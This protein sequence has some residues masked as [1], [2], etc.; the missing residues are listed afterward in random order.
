MKRFFPGF[1]VSIL[2]VMIMVCGAAPSLAYQPPVNL[3]G[4]YQSGNMF[5]FWAYDPQ[6][7]QWISDQTD[8]TAVNSNFTS[9]DGIYIIAWIAAKFGKQ[10]LY[11]VT[12]DRYS[13][14][15]ER[16]G[17][18]PYDAVS[19]LTVQDGVVSFVS[20]EGTQRTLRFS[21]YDPGPLLGEPSNMGLPRLAKT[22]W[23]SM[24]MGWWPGQSMMTFTCLGSF[25]PPFTIREL[26][27]PSFAFFWQ[28]GDSR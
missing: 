17:L 28:M 12:Y 18:V 22:V 8:P 14:K 19:G 16:T 6:L 13:K 5:Y 15:I 27:E 1:L 26:A 7:Q 25:T 10:Y 21:T 4:S 3:D 11:M 20:L 24:S 23:W 9:D 2:A